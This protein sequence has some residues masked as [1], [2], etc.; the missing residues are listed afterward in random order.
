MAVT[1]P[2][3]I[4][5]AGVACGIKPGGALDLGMIVLDAPGPWAATFTRSAAAAAPV[6]WSRAL[7]GGD[8]QAIVVNSG[9]ANACTGAAG[10]Q[11]VEHTACAAAARLACAPSEVA[12]ASTGPIGV[13]L[14]L[15]KV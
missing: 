5:S 8:L 15:P 2:G 1:W 4:R 13:P 7:L 11:T 14:P 10:A 3:G 6:L 9:N 12:V